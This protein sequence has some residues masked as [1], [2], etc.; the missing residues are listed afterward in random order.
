MRLTRRDLCLRAAGAAMCNIAAPIFAQ[1]WPSRPVRIVVTFPAGG[2]ND[3]IA[4]IMGQ[5]L[6]ERLGQAFIID[7]RVGGS[8]N[9]GAAEVVRAAPDGYTLLQATVS[10]ATNAALFDN[11]NFNFVADVAPVAGIYAVPLAIVV[12]PAFPAKTI[13]E[14]IAYAKA[15][16]GK[17]TYGTGGIGTL[18]HIAGELFKS[19]AGIDMVHLPYR[20]SPPAL[21][22]LLGGRFEVLFD[23][24]PTSIEYIRT[25]GLRG[26]A[27]TGASRSSSLPDIPTVGEFLPGFAVSVWVGIAAPKATPEEL[28]VRLNRQIN[29]VL[30]DPRFKARLAAMGASTLPGSPEEFAALIASDTRKWAKV[31]KAANIKA[32]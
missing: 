18:S 14:F 10:N 21:V 30:A 2:A 15:N 20:G 31:V 8:G 16:P 29:A 3:I 19:M 23:P 27:L 6:S 9:I 25:G 17:L 13:P 5:A 32:E 4:R 26:L 22:D 28:V 7:N 12:N 11:L 1:A 24:L